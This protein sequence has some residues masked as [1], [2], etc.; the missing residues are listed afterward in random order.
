MIDLLLIILKST[1]EFNDNE[2]VIRLI[3]KGNV[4]AEL[5]VYDTQLYQKLKRES[6]AYFKS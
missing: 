5:K 4:L 6:K 3:K 1:V 2:Q